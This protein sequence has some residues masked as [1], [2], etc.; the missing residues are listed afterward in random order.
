MTGADW[1]VVALL[2]GAVI[3]DIAI[4]QARA[5]RRRRSDEPCQC[6]WC[7]QTRQHRRDR[8]LGRLP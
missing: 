7:S 6:W 5:R 8:E 3:V 4:D 1:L 2:V